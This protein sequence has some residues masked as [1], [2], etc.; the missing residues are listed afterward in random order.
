MVA[1]AQ[2]TD[3][4]FLADGVLYEAGCISG[5]TPGD[6]AAD[7]LETTCL[8]ERESRT[9]TSGLSNPA[10][11]SFTFNYDDKDPAMAKLWDLKKSK[12][13]VTWLIAM[14][15]GTGEP[16]IAASDSTTEVYGLELPTDRACLVFTG[17]VAGFSLDFA[18]NALVTGTVTITR[19][20]ATEL[21]PSSSS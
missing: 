21:I 1:K 6:E 13:E 4:Y 20:G 14:S 3:L 7:Q 8:S 15:Q 2:G 18:Q 11:A 19:S 12:D 16:T 9:Y 10:Q 17:E 5:I